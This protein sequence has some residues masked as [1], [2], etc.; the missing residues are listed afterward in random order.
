MQI[1]VD[2]QSVLSNWATA[3]ELCSAYGVTC[4][5][6]VKDFYASVGLQHLVIPRRIWSGESIQGG[7][8][9]VVGAN[10]PGF[11]IGGLI[12]DPEEFDEIVSDCERLSVSF[13]GVV[14]VNLLDDREGLSMDDV[15]W[16]KEIADNNRSNVTLD[17]ALITSGCMHDKTPTPEEL[18]EA[19]DVLKSLGFSSV[20]VG[21]SFYLGWLIDGILPNN[22][23]D[24][25][26]GEYVLYGTI[27]YYPLKSQYKGSACLSVKL[28][29][30]RVYEDRKQ[31]LL[32]GGAT[33]LNSK[34]CEIVDRNFS[35][36]NSS[37]EYTIVNYK[38][39]PRVGDLVEMVPDYFSLSKL[40]S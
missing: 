15:A 35:F 19:I 36:S 33:R 10:Q 30:I 29:I 12:T 22:V 28:P 9:Y 27:P 21:G 31:V 24:I 20:S 1:I 17:T 32:L 34:D 16:L 25:R 18:K 4:S 8:N 11:H 6:M 37:T 3:E 23:D 40:L 13:E 2:R 26:L 39:K 7:F 38:E 5:L 14:P